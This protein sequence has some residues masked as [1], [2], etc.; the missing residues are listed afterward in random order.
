M[1]MDIKMDVLHQRGRPWYVQKRNG[2]FGFA[3]FGRRIFG[4]LSLAQ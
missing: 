2:L 1:R 4:F 3:P